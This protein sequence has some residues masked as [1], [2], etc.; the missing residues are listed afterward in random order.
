MS[1]PPKR[2]PF[3]G[4]VLLSPQRHVVLIDTAK[5]EFQCQRLHGTPED[6]FGEDALPD[7]MR[8]KGFG[9]APIEDG[10]T[11]LPIDESEALG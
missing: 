2:R 10:W 5:R 7:R 3:I 1:K 11:E 4:D 6:H 8:G 9:E